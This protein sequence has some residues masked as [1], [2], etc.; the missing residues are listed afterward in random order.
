MDTERYQR[1]RD[2]LQEADRLDGD[3]A[4]LNEALELYRKIGSPLDVA[5]CLLYLG[6]LNE[7][8]A[9]AK[10]ARARGHLLLA[11]ARKGDVEPVVEMLENEE[12][13]LGLRHQV[14]A[15][16]YLW[17]HSEH[18]GHLKEAEPGRTRSTSTATSHA[19]DRTCTSIA[20]IVRPSSG[21]APL[22]WPAIT[23]SGR[24]SWVEYEES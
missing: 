7:A 14:E 15:R 23:D 8:T 4:A 9:I 17:E 10:E 19:N 2:A 11:L 18:R 12:A 21:S 6:Q 1:I 16:Y 13:M 3:E 20:T 24:G 5:G 22:S